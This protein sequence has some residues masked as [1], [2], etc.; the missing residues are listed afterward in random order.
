MDKVL[1][2]MTTF[3]WWFSVVIMGLV[4]A[5]L[6]SY[7]MRFADRI[8]A[9]V[10][11]TLVNRSEAERQRRANEI[12]QAVANPVLVQLLIAERASTQ[13][14]GLSCVLIAFALVGAA[15]YCRV[16][17]PYMMFPNF[18]ARV[19]Y[20]AMTVATLLIAW[21]F[22]CQLLAADLF[23]I[24]QGVEARHRQNSPVLNPTVSCG[25]HEAV[26]K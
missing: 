22:A 7:A 21:S 19:P 13:H 2:E 26:R 10:S 15:M 14:R 16:H 24:L 5:V 8:T 12:E 4:V 6:G 17:A 1:Q 9:R 3:E 23:I 18:A 25:R 11:A 20:G